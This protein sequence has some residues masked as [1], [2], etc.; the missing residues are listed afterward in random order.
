MKKVIQSATYL[1]F[2]YHGEYPKDKQY[3]AVRNGRKIVEL[4]DDFDF[5]WKSQVQYLLKYADKYGDDLEI[6][7]YGLEDGKVTE[8]EAYMS[9]EDH[10]IQVREDW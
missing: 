4:L 6:A 8:E 2:D 1:E 7:I 5:S 3:I 10:S 9:I